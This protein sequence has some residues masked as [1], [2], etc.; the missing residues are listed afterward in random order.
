MKLYIFFL[1]I[2][3]FFFN[4][5]IL[6]GNDKIN[7]LKKLLDEDLITQGEFKDAMSKLSGIDEVTDEVTDDRINIKKSSDSKRK[8][9]VKYEF[10]LD[11]YRIHTFRPGSIR[12]DNLLTGETVVNISG[13][14][15]SKFTND[16]YKYFDLKVDK[17]NLS[18]KLIYKGRMLINW[19][20]KYVPKHRATFYQMQVL[21]YMPF[22]FY[23][24]IVG[25]N[26]IAI[27]M[28]RFNDK[29]DK[30]VDKVK[31]ELALKYD[32]SI[33]DIDRILEKKN[34]SIDS[35]IENVISKEKEKLIKELTDKYA[36]EEITDAIRQEIER[37]IGEEMANALIDEIQKATGV[38]IDKAIENE[39]ADAINEAI[40]EAIQLGVS[41]AAA[42]AAI[43][44]M[45]WVYANGGSDADAM[46]ACRAHA[47]D[48]C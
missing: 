3:F 14:F 22:H 19:S 24:M 34:K 39:L 1:F 18:A 20:G 13:N 42:E 21:G 38:A 37:T 35:E 47:G 36:G 17:E 33:N 32:I 16:G 9:F 23:I 12:V 48:A 30:A 43:A 15:K 41:Q 40:A 7:S 25:K 26:P 45:L 2:I 44:A 4:T 8:K 10:Y 11:N 31:N 29:I 27:N 46:A 5:K 6:L 28:D